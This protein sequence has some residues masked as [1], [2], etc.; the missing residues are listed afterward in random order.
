MEFV[1]KP[2]PMKARADNH[3]RF[4]FFPLIPDIILDR[5]ALSVMSIWF[6]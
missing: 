4:V 3:F 6:V 5:V 2:V 1:S